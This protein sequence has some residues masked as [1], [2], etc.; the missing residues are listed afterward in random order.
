MQQEWKW[1]KSNLAAFHVLPGNL[2]SMTGRYDTNNRAQHDPARRHTH[3]RKIL[4]KT[5]VAPPPPYAG[6]VGREIIQLVELQVTGQK[7]ISD[8][9]RTGPNSDI[10]REEKNA[11]PNLVVLE[12]AGAWEK[13]RSPLGRSYK[14]GHLKRNREI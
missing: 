11:K 10:G 7:Q 13:K 12:L 14:L 1:L 2:L 5:V 8:Y 6:V 3:S 9:Q 4:H